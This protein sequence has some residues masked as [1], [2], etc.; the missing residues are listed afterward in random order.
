MKVARL[1]SLGSVPTG[2]LYTI[3]SQ[4]T[5]LHSTNLKRRMALGAVGSVIVISCI[6]TDTRRAG[7]GNERIET[8]KGAPNRPVQAELCALSISGQDVPN[9]HE[10]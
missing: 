1:H 2:A 3:S 4:P 6:Y 8:G 10:H 7:T 5:I 9:A